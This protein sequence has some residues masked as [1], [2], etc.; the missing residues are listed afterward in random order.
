MDL[1]DI[2]RGFVSD[3]AQ[4]VERCDVDVLLKMTVLP[5]AKGSTITSAEA[6]RPIVKVTVK[7]TETGTHR[8]IA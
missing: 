1:G 2:P 8:L 6:P 3:G 7:P 5:Q 4:L